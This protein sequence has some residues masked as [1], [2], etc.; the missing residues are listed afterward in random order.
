MTRSPSVLLLL[1]PAG[2]GKSFFADYLTRRHGWLH[3]EMDQ[4]GVDG[5]DFHGIRTE[6]DLFLRERQPGTL[7]SELMRRASE[8]DRQHCIL[9][10]PSMIALSP[11]RTESCGESILIRYLT[12]P[13]SHCREAFLKREREN[14]RGF[15]APYWAFHNRFIYRALSDPGIHPYCVPAFTPQGDRRSPEDI[16]REMFGQI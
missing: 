3:L 13:E 1:G 9:T 7:I 12:G 10:F 14:G 5:I 16:F 6:W 2:V 8:Q 4:P 11:V 15:D